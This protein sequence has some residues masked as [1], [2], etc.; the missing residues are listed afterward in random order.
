[1]TSQSDPDL[2]EAQSRAI[3]AEV[4]EALAR[5]RM[6]R[7]QLAHAAR[8]SLSTLEKAL[9]G[10]RP[11]TLATTVRLEEALGAPLRPEP[12]KAG[13]GEL[14][15]ESLGAYARPA[16][17]WLEGPYLTLRLSFDTPGAV[18]AYRTEIAWDA[19]ASCLAFR[20]ADRLDAGFTQSGVV[21]L[22][23]Q[24]GHVYLVTNRQGQHRMIVLGRP[25][26]G[27]ELHGLI[28][29]LHAGRGSQLTPVSSPMVLV[30]L[31]GREAPSYGLVGPA[32]AAFTSYR[33]QLRR[34][35]DG[36]YARLL[37][38]LD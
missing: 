8:I 4:R 32:D 17:A 14:A 11:F 1:M 6:S 19:G 22:P 9:A 7:E 10:R 21:A 12:D 15:P 26:T 38:E 37:A 5:R 3:A 36:G 20:E 30:P 33:Q 18:Y 24:S 27:G 28:A 25:T 23:N 13:Q 35:L 29:T 31:R 2:S 16:V 34:T